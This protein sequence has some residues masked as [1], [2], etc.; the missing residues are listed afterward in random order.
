MSLF[1]LI[2]SHNHDIPRIFYRLYEHKRSEMRKQ[3]IAKPCHI[4]GLTVKP[5]NNFKCLCCV[6]IDYTVRKLKK[7]CLSRKSCG[8]ANNIFIN[9]RADCNASVKKR[10]SISQRT[11]CNRC[12]KHC[13]TVA[14][15]H[16][17]LI[18]NIEQSVCYCTGWDSVKIETLTA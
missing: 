10:K 14:Q 5:V 4:L 9:F 11:V 1:K 18:C 12:G 7:I 2:V 17:L 8:T 6:L 16:A 13:G 3:F 15:C